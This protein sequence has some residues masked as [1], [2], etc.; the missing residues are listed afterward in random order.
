MWCDIDDV[1]KT[2]P[3]E[4]LDVQPRVQPQPYDAYDVEKRLLMLGFVQGPAMQTNHEHMHE[5]Y[6]ARY[7]RWSI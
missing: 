4:Y 5:C 7:R 2:L 3:H 1:R 6:V